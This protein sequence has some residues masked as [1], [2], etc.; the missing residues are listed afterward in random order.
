M[1]H[2]LLKLHKN[3]IQNNLMKILQKFYNFRV[4]AGS[5]SILKS[6]LP[7]SFGHCLKITN[8]NNDN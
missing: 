5:H 7:L 8:N 1:F 3:F 2:K 6:S 4:F